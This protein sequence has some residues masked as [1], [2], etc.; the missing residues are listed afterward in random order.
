VAKISKVK[1]TESAWDLI[2]TTDEI[3]ADVRELGFVELFASDLKRISGQEPRILAKMDFSSQRP[4]SFV[5]NNLNILPIENGKYRIGNFD[6][7]HKVDTFTKDPIFVHSPFEFQSVSLNTTSE[8]IALRKAEIST[9]IDQFCGEHV[10]HTFSG[11]ERSA[12]FDFR[13]KNLDKSYSEINVKAV[14]VE[15]DGG[16]EG[17][18]SVYIFEVKNLAS[19]DFNIR[20]LYY[21]F[22][23][24]QAKC[25]KPIRCIYL[26][27]SDDVFTFH[28]YRFADS[29]NMS[30]IQLVKSQSY[31]IKKPVVELQVAM[32]SIKLAKWKPDFTLPFPQADDVG[33]LIEIARIAGS[34]GVTNDVIKNLFDFSPRQFEIVMG[35]YPNAARFLGLVSLNSGATP[36]VLKQTPE[37]ELAV[38]NSK[39]AVVALVVQRIMQIDGVPNILKQWQESGDMP[40]LE[41]VERELLRVKE[42]AKLGQSTRN[43][44]ARTIR[45][46]CI[47]VIQHTD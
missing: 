39:E 23:T 17:A 34:E 36:K 42:F 27:H 45:A 38:K 28:E 21:P 13:V 33:T 31:Y 7:F 40:T 1:P 26:V 19:V 10:V 14:Q 44:R 18:S 8:G 30:S 9:M 22:R 4:T 15:I 41:D 6:V 47:W 29:R 2:L 43:R 25:T 12:T 3:A 37:F 46:W 24:Y 11:R 5:E 32:E 20:Q 16:F 35:Y